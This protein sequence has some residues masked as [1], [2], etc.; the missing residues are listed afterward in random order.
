[1]KITKNQLKQIIKEE[2]ASVLKE[3]AMRFEPTDFVDTEERHIIRKG[4]TLWDLHK[5]GRFG[6]STIEDVIAYNNRGADPKDYILDPRNLPVGGSIA[7]PPDGYKIGQD[8][9]GD[10]PEFDFTDPDANPFDFDRAS[11]MR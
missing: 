4:D 1:M 9:M 11:L 2:L 10:D 7:I 6:D 3:G 8:P 5:A